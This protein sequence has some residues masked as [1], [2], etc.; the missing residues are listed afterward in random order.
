MGITKIVVG[1]CVG[2]IAAVLI[3]GI[4]DE[5]LKPY[6][7]QAAGGRWISDTYSN[8]RTVAFCFR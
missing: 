2:I 5:A 1:V 3:L 7:C 8:G 4:L 6:A